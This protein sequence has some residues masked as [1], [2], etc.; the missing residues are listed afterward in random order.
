VSRSYRNLVLLQ[1]GLTADAKF[2]RFD[3]GTGS[4]RMRVATTKRWADKAGGVQE[5]TEY[6]NVVKKLFSEAQINFFT[7]RLVKGA[8]VDVEGE[9][10]HREYTRE[11][12]EKAVITE[13]VADR[14]QPIGSTPIASTKPAAPEAPEPPAASQEPGDVVF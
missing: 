6:H 8:E 4:L 14:I 2:H 7:E 9:L 10:T 1:G 3:D 11:D 12:G 13:V 5:R